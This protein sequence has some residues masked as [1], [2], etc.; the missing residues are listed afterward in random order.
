M[1][2]NEV[3]F[4]TFIIYFRH[5]LDKFN[6]KKY[7]KGQQNIS[8]TTGCLSEALKLAYWIEKEE[9]AAVPIHLAGQSLHAFVKLQVKLQNSFKQKCI[10]MRK[11]PWP[12]SG[13][14]SGG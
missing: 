10:L 5:K 12:E 6:F 3:Y 11:N 13:A 8:S 2:T 9:Q 1:V 14:G 4:A 7:K